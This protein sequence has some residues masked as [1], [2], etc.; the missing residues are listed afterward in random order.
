MLV[1]A[2]VIIITVIITLM[3]TKMDTATH[4]HTLIQMATSKQFTL[5]NTGTTI[6]ITI[7]NMMNV[8][9]IKPSSDG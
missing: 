3:I 7:M 4:T 9:S 8:A 5:M 6:I 1:K 2:T